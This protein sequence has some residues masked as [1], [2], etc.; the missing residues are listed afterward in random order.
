MS[1]VTSLTNMPEAQLNRWLK[2]LGLLFMVLLVAFVAF[3]AVD[4]FRAKPAPIADQRVV[5]LEA[6]VQKDPADISS[7]GQLADAYAAKGRWE[8]AIAQYSAI[9]DANKNVELAKF[10]RAQA[11]VATSQLDKA[12]ADFQAVVDIA[13]DGEMANVDPTLEAAYYGLGDIAMKQ[14]NAQEAVTQLEKALFIKK[15]DSDALLLIGKAYTVTGQTDKAVVALR[16]A[17]KFVPI[18]WVEPYQ[19]MADAYTKAGNTAEAAWA[20]AMVAYQNGD[21]GKASE[22]LKALVDGPAALDACIG[23]GLIAETSN[24]LDEARTWYG[25]ALAID[26]TNEEAMLGLGRVGGNAAA[27]PAAPS[28]PAPSASGGNP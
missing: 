28:Q 7:R 24:K 19:A 5:A 23:L 22:Q 27:S 9:I 15:T 16:N 4:R 3:Y 13:K 8:E 12:K 21:P 6:A 18:G 26:A 25:K 17:V 11:Y 1:R 2:R 10:K 20:N 14:N